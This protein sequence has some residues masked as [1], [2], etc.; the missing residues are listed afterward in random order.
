MKSL[1]RGFTKLLDALHI[2]WFHKPLCRGGF[3]K[4]LMALYTYIHISV[5]F[6]L[7]ADMEGMV[8]GQESRNVFFLARHWM[9]CADMHRTIMCLAQPHGAGLVGKV[10]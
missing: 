10:S 8:G 5:F 9:K 1:Y 3:V 7:P 2:V 6:F 4:P